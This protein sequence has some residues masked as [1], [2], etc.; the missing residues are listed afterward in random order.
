MIQ[1]LKDAPGEKSQG[2]GTEP[3]VWN[4]R[5]RCQDCRY[6]LKFTPR[7]EIKGSL[8]CRRFP[9]AVVGIPF[10]DGTGNVTLDIRNADR[11]IGPDYWCHEFLPRV[12]TQ[13]LVVGIRDFSGLEGEILGP[14]DEESGNRNG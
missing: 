4:G 14:M 10:S 9:P 8:I 6:V 1:L 3:P 13:R 2:R 12:Q 11:P 5:R 7:G